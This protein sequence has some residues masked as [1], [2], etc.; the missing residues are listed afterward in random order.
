MKLILFL[1][2]SPM[3][4]GGIFLWRPFV[5]VNGSQVP[6]LSKTGQN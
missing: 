2:L 3:A 1:I 4:A 6:F 5:C